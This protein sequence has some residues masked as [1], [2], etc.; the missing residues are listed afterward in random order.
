MC[1]NMSKLGLLV[2]PEG[3]KGTPK[4]IQLTS[5]GIL[6]A[7]VASTCPLRWKLHCKSIQSSSDLTS[8]SYDETLLMGVPG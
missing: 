2:A 3:L 8:L 7:W 1:R 5:V 4:N 6:V